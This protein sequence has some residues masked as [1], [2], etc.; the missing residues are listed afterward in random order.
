MEFK[1]RQ[2]KPVN[3][4]G[5]TD[6]QENIFYSKKLKSYVVLSKSGGAAAPPFPPPLS[7]STSQNEL[8]L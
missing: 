5:L 3:Q 4:V 2:R 7:L 8:N 6:L 1:Q